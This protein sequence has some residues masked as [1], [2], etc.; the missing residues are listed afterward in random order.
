MSFCHCCVNYNVQEKGAF[1][2]KPTFVLGVLSSKL[3]VSRI[4][5]KHVTETY[6][7]VGTY[8]TVIHCVR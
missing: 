1:H 2:A 8:M 4:L 3:T 6:F 7:A 5:D